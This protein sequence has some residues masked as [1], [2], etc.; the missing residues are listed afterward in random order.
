MGT[1]KTG[2]CLV[3]GKET[4]KLCSKCAKAGH[5]LFF[6]SPEHQK[7]V[8][9]EHRRVCGRRLALDPWPWY[10]QEE[11]DETIANLDT[12]VEMHEGE[13]LIS[14][15][16]FLDQEAKVPA[17][18][19]AQHIYDFTVGHNHPFDLFTAQP[20]LADFRCM[21]IRRKCRWRNLNNVLGKTDVF[22]VIPEFWLH[23]CPGTPVG[24]AWY[25]GMQHRVDV[26]FSPLH[27]DAQEDPNVPLAYCRNAYK[28]VEE[29]LLSPT[30][31]VGPCASLMI[32]TFR[33]LI[34]PDTMVLHIPIL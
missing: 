8:W 7:L 10:S 21:E 19:T 6:C 24:V 26:L 31:S 16:E 9:A 32:H 15:T 20:A 22:Q 4:E 30:S 29:Y 17:Y 3:C 12:K 13:E 28:Q 23:F 33:R 14:L 25:A 5:D 1:G 18:Y 2:A 11:A 34:D 27:Q